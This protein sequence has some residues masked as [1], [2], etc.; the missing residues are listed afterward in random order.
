LSQPKISM[1]QRVVLGSCD[2]FA[3]YE[4]GTPLRRYDGAGVSAGRRRIIREEIMTKLLAAAAVAATLTGCAM[5]TGILPAGPD[6]YTV[7]EHFAPIRGGSTTAQQTALTE[8][9]AFCAGQG[10]QFL[11][12]D[13]L[14]PFSANPYGT[15]NYSVTF[16]CLSPGDPELAR[17]HLAPTQ[18]IEQRNR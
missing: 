17:S 8:A 10:R 14:T 9:N 12:V 3:D 15:T 1:T 2:V 16:R 6:T 7:S 13:M 11:P 18:I 4:N 5:S